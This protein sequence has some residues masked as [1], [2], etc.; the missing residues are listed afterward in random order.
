[1]VNALDEG[2][3]IGSGNMFFDLTVYLVHHSLSELP[4]CQLPLAM[5]SDAIDQMI[6][7]AFMPI[8]VVNTAE[9]LALFILNLAQS[10]QT[11]PH[12]VK[13]TIVEGLLD[14]CDLKCKLISE[15]SP[16]QGQAHQEDPMAAKALQ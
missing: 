6:S 5:R 7:L 16:M 4:E 9:L 1:M 15:Q 13:P 3:H 8:T 2:R 10:P 12:L 11:H 14:V